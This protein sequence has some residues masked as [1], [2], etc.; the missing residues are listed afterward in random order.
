MCPEH[1]AKHPAKYPAVENNGKLLHLINWMT[2]HMERNRYAVTIKVYHTSMIRNDG[3]YSFLQCDL[4]WLLF[5]D[6]NK[7]PNNNLVCSS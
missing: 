1:H 7:T 3:F 2:M 5:K 6:K 4:A